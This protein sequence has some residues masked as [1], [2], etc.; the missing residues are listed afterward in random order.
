MATLE[1]TLALRVR[2]VAAAR[3]V[4][5]SHVA[6]RA[7]ISRSHLWAVLKCERSATLGM[8]QRLAEAIGVA[9]IELLD[10]NSTAAE[11][12]PKARK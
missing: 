2:A 1:K 6:D 4:A 11:T 3:G 12:R 7:G 5:L 10:A 8:V 9:P